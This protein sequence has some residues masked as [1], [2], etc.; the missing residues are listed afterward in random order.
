MY[1]KQKKTNNHL[2]VRHMVVRLRPKSGR[3]PPA[4]T[5]L[6][7]VRF[8]MVQVLSVSRYNADDLLSSLLL[9]LILL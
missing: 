1:E 7:D 2:T 4:M 5:E 3:L 6:F 8:L 9:L